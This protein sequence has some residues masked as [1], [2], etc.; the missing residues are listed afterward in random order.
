MI[1]VMRV[2]TYI[3]K[4]RDEYLNRGMAAVAINPF[5]LSAWVE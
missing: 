2:G 3:R 4:K 1:K 5:A